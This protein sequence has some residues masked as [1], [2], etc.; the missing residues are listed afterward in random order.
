[1]TVL[2]KITL[3]PLAAEIRAADSWIL[4]PF[5]ADDAVFDESAIRSAQ[6]LKL[7]MERGPVRGY[8]PEP[9]RSIF[10]LDTPS[11]D[12]LAKR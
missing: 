1:M 8:F 9:A 10:F 7:L 2:Y 12:D 3:V 6:L 5:Y 4:S 11:Q